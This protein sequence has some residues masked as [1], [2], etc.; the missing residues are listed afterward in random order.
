MADSDSYTTIVDVAARLGRGPFDG[1]SVPTAVQVDRMMQQRAGQVSQAIIKGGVTASPPSGSAPISV[2]TP[3]GAALSQVAA[4]ANCL[5]AAGDAAAARSR[6]TE[7]AGE[8]AESL[9]YWDEG[10]RLLVTVEAIALESASGS[11][12]RSSNFFS[13]MDIPDL[14]F[15][16]DTE[17]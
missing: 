3:Q 1:A 6:Q 14:R 4:L 5:L 13:N 17:F 15:N 8:P 9:A 7:G 10:L 16:L 11:S 2:A 12:A